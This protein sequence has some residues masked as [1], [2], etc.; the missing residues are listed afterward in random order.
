[1]KIK[2]GD[3]VLIISGKDKGKSGKVAQV[4]AK[5]DKIVVEGLNKALKHVKRSGNQAGQKVEYSAPVHVSN[6][7]VMKGEERGRVGYKH[8][9][10]NGSTKKVRTLKTKKG[11]EDLE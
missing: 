5:M 6:V 4:L 2:V 7:Q 8:I 1:M 3:K 11:R 9:E 10:K